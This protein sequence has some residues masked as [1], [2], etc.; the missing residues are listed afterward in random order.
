MKYQVW[1][2]TNEEHPSPYEA[3]PTLLNYILPGSN[4]L[5]YPTKKR[6]VS[7][8]AMGDAKLQ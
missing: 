6:K 8:L 2:F 3:F 7:K 4:M 5:G 1:K